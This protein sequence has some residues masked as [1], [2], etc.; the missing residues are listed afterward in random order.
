MA[1]PQ[2]VYEKESAGARQ[3]S[4][5]PSQKQKTLL[6]RVKA[7]KLSASWGRSLKVQGPCSHQLA[8]GVLLSSLNTLKD[9]GKQLLN[10]G[11]IGF[12]RYPSWK[13]YLC[14]LCLYIHCLSIG[15]FEAME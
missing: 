14:P 9:G 8:P 11:P 5:S 10:I 13:I 7:A 15:D 1:R 6:G 3:K 2:R 12:I 4:S